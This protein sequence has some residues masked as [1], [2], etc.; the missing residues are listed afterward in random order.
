[1]EHHVFTISQPSYP[2]VEIFVF[3]DLQ[4]GS[5]GF[6]REAW[7]EFRI[8]FKRAKNA[9]G[10]GVG[11]YGD[12]LRP[13]MRE[14]LEATLKKD[15]SA[16]KQLDDII[17]KDHDRIC[18]NLEFLKGKMIG[19]HEG[20]HTW[21]FQ[22]GITTDQRLASALKTRF[23]GFTASTRM[24]LIRESKRNGGYVY[25][26]VSTHGNANG[27]KVGA[28]ANW[29]ESNIVAGFAADHYIMGHGC[30]NATFVPHAVDSVRRTGAPGLD[31][32][33]PRCLIVGGFADGYTNGHESSYVERSG[34]SPQ[35]L[36][37]GII[38]LKVVRRAADSIA[39][40]ISGRCRSETIS[41]EQMN[42]TP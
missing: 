33:T 25:T 11:D 16:K 28:A 30:K 34:F 3:G 27:R 31:R 17:L 24:V 29:L 23:L 20:H 14:R 18:D 22:S 12:W 2:E 19:L 37:W 42:I 7:E 9:Y 36:G 32:R 8:Q 35:P 6:K 39:K 4:D 21:K 1:M 13:S 41:V 26:M 10:L 40:G 15:D 5:P 38:R